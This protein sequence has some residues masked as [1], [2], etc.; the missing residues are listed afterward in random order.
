[1]HWFLLFRICFYIVN[2]PILHMNY[3]HHWTL[4]FHM[5]HILFIFTYPF[6]KMQYLLAAI[7]SIH[8]GYKEIR[9][10]LHA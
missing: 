4:K 5:Y 10:I 2:L 8:I 7:L 3:S 1:M 9:S 6:S